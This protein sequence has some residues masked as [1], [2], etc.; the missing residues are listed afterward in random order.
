MLIEEIVDERLMTTA[1]QLVQMQHYWDNLSHL[2]SDETKKKNMNMRFGIF[3]IK[4][5]GNKIVSFDC[6]RK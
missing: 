4:L 5:D 6:C 1:Q 2:A 3:D